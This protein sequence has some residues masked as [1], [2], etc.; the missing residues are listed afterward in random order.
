MNHH[1]LA[2]EALIGIQTLHF[3]KLFTHRGSVLVPFMT[4]QRAFA[5]TE[6]WIKLETAPADSAETGNIAKKQCLHKIRLSRKSVWHCVHVDS[7]LKHLPHWFQ[8][9]IFPQNVK[10]PDAYERLI[11]DVFCGNQ[12]HFVRRFVARMH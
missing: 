8:T 6:P 12:M 1:Q 9:V 3:L 10:L 2:N 7:M 11:L 4:T 5:E